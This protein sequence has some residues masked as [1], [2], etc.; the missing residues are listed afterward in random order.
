MKIQVDIA[1]LVLDGMAFS[2]GQRPLLQAT[3]EAELRR[4]LTVGG[5]NPALLAGGASPSLRVN[6]MQLPGNND[7]VQLG[8]QVARSVYGG[9]GVEEKAR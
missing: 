5:L 7:P 6:A 8:Q 4:L 1:R 2:A 9:I 3:V